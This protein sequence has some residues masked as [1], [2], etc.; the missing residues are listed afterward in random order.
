MSEI[1]ARVEHFGLLIKNF[2]KTTPLKSSYLT[3]LIAKFIQTKNFFQ[4]PIHF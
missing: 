4:E 2:K 3:Y 1:K